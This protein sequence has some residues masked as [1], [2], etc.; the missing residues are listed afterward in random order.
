MRKD[1]QTDRHDEAK[2]RFSQFCE[3]SLKR[4]VD[5]LIMILKPTRILNVKHRDRKRKIRAVAVVVLSFECECINP[6]I[7]SNDRDANTAL[8]Q[9]LL[10]KQ[11]AARIPTMHSERQRILKVMHENFDFVLGRYMLSTLSVLEQIFIESV[12]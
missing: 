3:K 2:S 9:Q 12:L 10:P 4:P 6:K 5:T 8:S 7:I 1:T 11:A